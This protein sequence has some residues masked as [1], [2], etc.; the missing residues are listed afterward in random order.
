MSVEG[1]DAAVPKFDSKTN[2]TKT[3]LDDGGVVIS[4]NPT[5]NTSAKK[6]QDFYS[7]L[8]DDIDESDL[9][10][11]A[12]DLVE[13]IENDI[14]S[15]SEYHQDLAEGVAMLGFKLEAPRSDPANTGA[16]TEGMSRVYHPLMAEAC[17]RFQANARGELLP[18]EGPVKVEATGEDQGD[19]G[20]DLAEALESAMNR[21]FTVDA[22]EY[23]PD[24]IRMLFDVGFGG[25][26]FKKCYPCPIRRR[27]VSESIKAE[28][29]V[30]AD[31]TRDLKTCGRKTHIIEMDETTFR[32]MQILG[33]YRDIELSDPMGVSA[34]PVSLAKN[35]TAGVNRAAY[36]PKDKPR[37]LYET[38]A[39]LDVPGFEDKDKKG[40]STGLRLPYRVTIDK[41]SKTILEIRRNWSKDDQMKLEK[42]VFVKYP[43]VNAVSF[44]GIGLFHILGNI[45]RA[46]TAGLRLSLD[47]GMLSNFPAGLIDKRAARQ[48]SNDWRLSPGQLGQVDVPA[49]MSIRDIVQGLPYKDVSGSFLQLL[50]VLTQEGQRIGGTAEVNVGEGRQDAPVGTT[51]ALLE[52]A[53]KVTD[54]VHK[55]LHAAQAEEFQ[56]MKELFEED[57]EALF[58]HAPN[59]IAK[60]DVEKTLQALKRCDIVPRADPNTPS[61]MHRVMKVQALVQLAQTAPAMFGQRGM[62]EVAKLAVR[63]LGFE[64]VDK[65]LQPDANPGANNPQAQAEEAKAQAATTSAQAALLKAQTDAQDLA[66]RQKNQGAE[67]ANQA[68]DR[69]TDLQLEQMRLATE[70]TIHATKI[71]SDHVL[72][73]QGIAA[74][75][76]KQQV[77]NAHDTASQVSD[78]LHDLASQ[79][80]D[81]T[82]DIRSK[83][84][85]AALAPQPVAPTTKPKSGK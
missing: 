9:G 78:Q 85:D 23:Y 43:Y 15:V 64:N 6:K 37:T 81:Q 36:R 83:V 16:P 12:N 11:L 69:N 47:N 61:H 62:Q 27:P 58:R 52:Q 55:G 72:G 21:F 35:E 28:H 10:Q 38:Y 53:T 26:G 19:A 24:T 49:G 4:F 3:E 5:K 31:A 34:D 40:E 75:A 32:R 71:A 84:V 48:L 25:S 41:D 33:V 82:H 46:L 60:W 7:N 57:P 51:L 80:I 29:F 1:D 39:E 22:S 14:R 18:A 66:F 65:F 68:A 54:A 20:D 59:E 8:A 30:V 70:K 2:S 17:L 73:A 67:Y 63:T 76:R 13:G 56:I 74:D 42:R 79:R 77:D 44:Y 50:E 45:T